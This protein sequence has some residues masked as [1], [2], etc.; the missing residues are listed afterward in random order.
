MTSPHTFQH[1]I[2]KIA[3]K[4][5]RVARNV[6]HGPFVMIQVSTSWYGLK[7]TTSSKNIVINKL[8][9]KLVLQDNLRSHAYQMKECR[10]QYI[11]LHWETGT[12]LDIGKRWSAFLQEH[13]YSIRFPQHLL[14]NGFWKVYEL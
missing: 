5:E 8:F 9:L 13:D 4:V 3:Q 1:S 7:T 11:C 6:N 2:G 10:S 12:L 14:Q